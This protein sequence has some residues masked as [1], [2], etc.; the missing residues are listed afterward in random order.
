M[1]K[2]ISRPA[3]E[4]EAARR[5]DETPPRR[6]LA[7]LLPMLI[8]G[9]I[10]MFGIL[11]LAVMT[12]S[13]EKTLE[14]VDVISSMTQEDTETPEE[15]LEIDAPDATPAEGDPSESSV[16]LPPAEPMSAAVMTEVQT[17]VSDLHVDV[18]AEQSFSA[19]SLFREVGPGGS[20]GKGS[21]FG[22]SGAAAG[23]GRIV[24][25]GL[26]GRFFDLK[27]DPQRNKLPYTGEFPDYIR[28]M[29]R[30]VA[31]GLQ[32][33]VTRDYY[34]ADTKLNFSQLWIPAK[35]PATDAPKEFQVEGKVEPRGWFVHY[36]GTV[37]PPRKGEWRF[38]G[39]FDDMLVLY[40]N[41][42]P[43]LD[44][45]WVPMCNVGNG[46]YDQSLRQEFGGP[47][48]SG[49]RT[50]YAG[51]WINI[52]GPVQVDLLIGETPGG[53]VGGLL[54]CQARDT[55]YDVRAD[56]TPI[57]PLFA[58][59]NAASERIRQDPLAQ[60]FRLVD[61]PPIWTPIVKKVNK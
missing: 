41:R 29:N 60:Q 30:L 42:Q 16:E 53:L 28:S 21:L 57:L 55:R 14:I 31:G 33:S 27:Q 34:E 23:R 7:G 5:A 22:M 35:T 56:G 17:D 49:S 11:V 6:T 61:N 46:P 36:S 4:A 24:E 15:T 9:V 32:D 48:V 54:M 20:T 40:I 47:G 51:K 37:I 52:T 13:I 10:H 45:S 1:T 3:R 50:A 59:S 8:S 43:V 38:V 39:F 58:V 18:R 19:N 26:V 2:Q 12:T 44:G 25:T